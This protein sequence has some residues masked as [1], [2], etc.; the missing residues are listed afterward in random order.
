[1]NGSERFIVVTGGPGSGKSTLLDAL[2]AEGVAVMPEAGRAIIRD[3]VAIGGAALPWADSAAFAELM[4]SW[5]MRSWR[6]ADRLPH[7]VL[8]DRGVPD[9]IG[10]LELC[11]LPVPAHVGRAGELYRY[12][13]R[14]FIAPPWADIYVQDGE[15]KQSLDE[16]ARTH[17]AMAAVYGRLGYELLALPRTPVAERVRFVRRALGL[18][19]V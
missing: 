11:G 7:P 14:V 6:E 12:N 5:E 19:D 9:V 13:A 2:A 16:A 1:M 17:D 3:Q 15:R 8:F 18:A 10:Y 4:L